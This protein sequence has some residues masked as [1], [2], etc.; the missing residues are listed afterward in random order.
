[1]NRRGGI[2]KGGASS[3]KMRI[4]GTARKSASVPGRA[5]IQELTLT[6]QGVG[7]Y[8]R[9]GEETLRSR[10]NSTFKIAIIFISFLLTD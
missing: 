3:S 6:R 4:L 8:R 7:E 5:P 2:R 9:T 1:M 10:L